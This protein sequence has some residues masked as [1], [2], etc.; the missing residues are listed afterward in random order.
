MAETSSALADAPVP[1]DVLARAGEFARERFVLPG[2]DP[3]LAL[4]K[5]TARRAALDDALA[6]IDAGRTEPSV[7]WRRGYSLLLG[8][9]RLLSEEEP[10]LADGTLLSPHQVDALSG[11]LIALTSEL[12]ENLRSGNGRAAAGNGR[13]GEALLGNTDLYEDDFVQASLRDPDADAL[14]EESLDEDDEDEDT[15][16][17]A[18][19]DQ[20]DEEPLDWDPAEEAE[21]EAAADAQSPDP[22]ADRRFWFEHATGA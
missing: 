21:E 2:E 1:G 18:D 15:E 22:G 11:T 13:P 20:A 4:A 8:L 14:D 17:E 16:P 19:E 6:E 9:E 3:G 10:H 5:G 12:E 7:E